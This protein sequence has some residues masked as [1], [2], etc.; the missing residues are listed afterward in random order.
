MLEATFFTESRKTVNSSCLRNS[1]V[2]VPVVLQSV[3]ETC[4]GYDDDRWCQNA[5]ENNL[6]GQ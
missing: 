6:S 3:D 4:K 5:V 2:V 1:K